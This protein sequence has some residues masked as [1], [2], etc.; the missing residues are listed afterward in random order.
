MLFKEDEVRIDSLQGDRNFARA[1]RHTSRTTLEEDFRQIERMLGKGTTVIRENATLRSIKVADSGF[2][3]LGYRSVGCDGLETKTEEAGID[4]ERRIGEY[5]VRRLLRGDRAEVVYLSTGTAVYQ[6]AL[7]LVQSDAT[8]TPSVSVILTDNLP[9]VELLCQWAHRNHK[10][11]DMA[12]HIL[13]GKADF[14][15]GDIVQETDLGQLDQWKC[16]AAVIAVTGVNPVTG[17]MYSF[18]QPGMKEKVL[19]DMKMAQVIIPVV[20]RQFGITGGRLIYDPERRDTGQ[21][22]RVYHVVTTSIDE[23]VKQDLAKHDYK[24]HTVDDSHLS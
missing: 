4:D 12:F 18:R 17:Q 15:T 5:I 10:L 13:G 23:R 7:A 2:A 22:G 24:V 21:E 16:S 6:V 11:S 3:R 8:D 20:P 9:I 19:R 1:F 14:N